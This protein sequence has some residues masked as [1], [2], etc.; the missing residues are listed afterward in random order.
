VPQADAAGTIVADDSGHLL[1]SHTAVSG[2]GARAPAGGACTGRMHNVFEA[3]CD[4][5]PSAIALECGAERLTYRELDERA[6]RLA[7]RLRDLGTGGSARTAILL[8]RS[9]DMYVALLAIGK[10]GRAFVPIDPE[11]PSDRIG[12]IAGDVDADLLL[13]SSEFAGSVAGL[14]CPTLLV[15]ECAA[16]LAQMPTSRP[17]LS[18]HHGQ[19][20]DPAAYVIYTSGSSGHPKGVEVPQSSIC[21]FLSVV[22]GV[23][24][25]RPS[26][27]VYQGMTIAFDFS[28]EEI[29]PTW[30][31]GATLVAGPTDSRRL[32]AELADFLDDM[33]VTLFYCVPTLLA[34]IPRELPRI[35]NLYVGGEAC[36]AQLVE[37]WSRPGRRILNT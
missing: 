1:D 24:D 22:P 18:S 32:G 17:R 36:P 29:W 8:Q 35:R 7:H 37:R 10:A 34:T 30:S 20:S 3:A 21:N 15:D 12:Y 19:E 23:Y 33:A 26:D 9:V 31:V 11:S 16:A 5:S 25:V 14:S 27:R 2:D 4:R 28:I 13:T 6:N